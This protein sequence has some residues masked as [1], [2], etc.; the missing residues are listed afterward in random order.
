MKPLNMKMLIAEDDLVIGRMVRDYFATTN[1]Q[2]EF[3]LVGDGE[4]ALEVAKR[5]LPDIIITDLMMPKKDG[6]TLIAELRKMPDFEVIPIVAI[7]AGND[8]TKI[9]AIE[10]G[11]SLVL[12]K[13]F[14]KTELIEKVD[15]LVSANPFT[16]K[17]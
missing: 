13:P 7:T 6:V 10:A 12:S 9:K 17:R 14:R 1:Q 2:Y 11:A 16:R 15:A 8:S 3:F 4:E 5:E